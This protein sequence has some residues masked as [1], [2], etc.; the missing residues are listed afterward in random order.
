MDNCRALVVPDVAR[1][2]YVIDDELCSQADGRQATEIAIAANS[3]DCMP[4]GAPTSNAVAFR[5]WAPPSVFPRSRFG[6]KWQ[7]SGVD[8]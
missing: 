4:S 1:W 5:V 6:T 8:A 3:P 7:F 2:T